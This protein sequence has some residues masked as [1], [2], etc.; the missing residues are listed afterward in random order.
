MEGEI[1]DI[2]HLV[3]ARLLYIISEMFH[4]KRITEQQRLDLKYCV[5]KD[6]PNIL[7][8]YEEFKDDIKLL[9]NKLEEIAKYSHYDGDSQ[10]SSQNNGQNIFAEN[11]FQ[12]QIENLAESRKQEELQQIQASLNLNQGAQT[13]GSG[14]LHVNVDKQQ[15]SSQNDELIDISS[16]LGNGA[17]NRKK[18]RQQ[19]ALDGLQD[20]SKG[21][22][23]EV[24][25]TNNST[26]ISIQGCDLGMS[27]VMQRFNINNRKK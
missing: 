25:N 18:E 4:Q 12:N 20:G 16:P 22:Q 13:S 21:G 5:L 24:N 1:F 26:Q 23:R 6:D 9:S 8:V 3:H 17:L 15:T 7:E 19:Q 10:A 2:L 14:S 11:D 27:P